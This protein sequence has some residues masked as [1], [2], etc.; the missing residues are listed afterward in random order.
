MA[1]ELS[2]DQKKDFAKLLYTTQRLTQAEIAS[3]VGVNHI[4]VNRWVVKEDWERLRKNLLVTKRERLAALYEQLSELTNEIASRQEGKRYAI[5]GEADTIAK[6]TASIKNL[7]TET[8]IGQAVDIGIAFLDYMRQTAPDKAVELSDMYDSFLKHL[9][10][11][12][13]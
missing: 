13:S 12:T 3:R 2:I 1:K 9:L 7:E 10:S 6:L 4:T 8:S 11:S 5:K